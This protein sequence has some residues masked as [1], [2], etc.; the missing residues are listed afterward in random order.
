MTTLIFLISCQGNDD[1][2]GAIIPVPASFTNVLIKLPI[3]ELEEGINKILGQQLFDGGFALNKKKDSLFLKIN[4]EERIDI[5]YYQGRLHLTLPLNISSIIKS[6]LLGVSIS[7]VANPI[8]FQAKAELS[9]DLNIDERWDLEFD[10]R[11]ETITWNEPPNFKVLGLKIDL[12]ELIEK[13][14]QTHKRP[15]EETINEMLK[16]QID[17]RAAVERL[18]RSIQ[19]P[20]KV[21]AKALP[22]YFT[23]E[24]ISLRGDFVK[25]EI[26]DTLFFQ[27]EHQSILRINDAQN[28]HQLSEVLPLRTNPLSRHTQIS[29][30]VELRLSFLKM[31]EVM[32]SLLVGKEFNLEGIAAKVNRVELSPHKG[33]LK[34]D[35]TVEGDI[36]GIISL[37]VVPS[38]D[39][40]LVMRIS[41]FDY[42]L[43]KMEGWAKITDLVMHRAIEKYVVSQS[44][45][46]MSPFLYSLDDRIARGLNKS[47]LSKKIALD[48]DLNTFILYSKGMNEDEIQFIFQIEGRSALSIK[49]KV[50]VQ[51]E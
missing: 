7:N 20:L 43:P 19:K 47:V 49:D 14:I 35:L 27:L 41:A 4:R 50:F 2:I 37:F 11:W 28:N 18:Y 17:L 21:S 5:E 3:A 8:K 30:F 16:D 39:E 33:F 38:I 12:A 36:N 46:D 9:L 31:E 48:L 45:Y 24:A 10:S 1:R 51:R 34:W 22:L 40:D 13:E 32:D 23:N 26:N 42:E 6:R 25:V 15:L 44:S 29:F